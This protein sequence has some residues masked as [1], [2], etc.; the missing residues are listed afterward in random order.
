[1]NVRPGAT[2]LG[3]LGTEFHVWAPR[4]RRIDVSLVDTGEQVALCEASAGWFSGVLPC[5]SGARYRYVLDGTAERPDPASRFQPEGVHGPSAVVRFGDHEWRDA[6]FEP[7]PLRDAVLYELHVATFTPAGTFAAAVAELDDL[8]SLGITAIEVMP[9]AQFPGS[10]NWGYDGVFPFAVQNTYGGPGAFQHFV[11]EC[12]GRGLAVILDVVYNHLG[13]EGNVLPDFAPYLTDRYLTPW[14][15]AVNL[16]GPGSDGVRHYLIANALQ[17]FEDFHV[18]GLRLDA[19]H[20]LIDR[21]ARPFLSE[22][23]ATVHDH[24]ET[25]GRANWLIAESADNDPRV[26]SEPAVGGLGLHAQWNDDFHHAVHVALTGERSGYYGDYSGAADVARAMD[27][28]FVYQGQ[29]SGFRARRHGAPSA[30]LEPGRF[31]VFAQNH[32]QVGNRAGGERLSALVDPA[33]LRLAAALVALS[34]GIPLLFMGEEYAEAVPFA[35]FVDHGDPNL[36]EAV[37]RG[38]AAEHGRDEVDPLDPADPDT[39]ERSVLDRDLRHHGEHREIW[40]TYRSLLALRAAEPALRRSGRS[41]TTAHAEGDVV[42]LT[43]SHAGTTIVSLFNLSAS[44]T[45]ERLPVTPASSCSWEELLPAASCPP[46]D[47]DGGVP[48]HP[49]QFRVFRA[50]ADGGLP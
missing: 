2:P 45:S 16:D 40:L 19:V 7:V 22:L 8:A 20:E 25:T 6:G 46:S 43:R 48:L 13:P 5:G 9:V 50:T 27:Q 44:E 37:R 32:D 12:H 35:Y 41:W 24:A 33:R 4:A 11:D 18:D 39:F 14:G 3:A 21:S 23:A 1:M 28:G 10:H 15:P 26:V 47:G 17:W 31:V 38:R 49:W 29:Y 36:V 30:G 42:T 34:P